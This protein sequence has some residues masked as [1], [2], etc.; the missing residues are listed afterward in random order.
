V[1]L[2]QIARYSI[3]CAECGFVW[4]TIALRRRGDREFDKAKR[5]HVRVH[6]TKRPKKQ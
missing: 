3:S 5:R 4:S 6:A 2:L 1:K